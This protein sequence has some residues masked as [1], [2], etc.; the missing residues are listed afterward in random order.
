MLYLSH[1]AAVMCTV[2]VLA[3]AVTQ[4]VEQEELVCCTPT[5]SLEVLTAATLRHIGSLAEK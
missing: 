3:T 1:L 2:S 4:H 5:M